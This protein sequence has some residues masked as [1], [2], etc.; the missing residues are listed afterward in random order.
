M[1]D[2]ERLLQTLVATYAY[3]ERELT[4]FALQV[5]VEDLGEH[6]IDAVCAAFV[7]HRRHPER[8]Q[9]LPKTA[10]ILRQLQG[11]SGDRAI[12]AWSHVLAE[13][14]RVGTYGRADIDAA[15]RKAVDGL[16]GWGAL[17]R[18]QESELSFLQRRFLDGY[19]V[20]HGREVREAAVHRL[21]ADN[22]LRLQ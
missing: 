8:G 10:D 21:D 19:A 2:R 11:G 5:W 15:T 4:D 12:E 22:V 7:A 3:Y 20:H 13:V 6:P 14:R 1:T 18:A 9:W 16:G 17:C